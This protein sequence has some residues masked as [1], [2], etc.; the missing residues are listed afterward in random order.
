[1][2]VVVGGASLA[3]GALRNRGVTLPALVP[4]VLIGAAPMA[5]ADVPLKLFGI[6]DP[7]GWEG[8]DWAADALPHLLYGLVIYATTRATDD[9]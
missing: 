1:M 6:S 2:G 5:L 9:L 7:S 3:L 4:I 8:K